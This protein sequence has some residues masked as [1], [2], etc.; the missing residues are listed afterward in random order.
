VQSNFTLSGKAADV[1]DQLK[2]RAAHAKPEPRVVYITTI[3][4]PES[5][6]RK[7]RPPLSPFHEVQ[8]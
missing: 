4:T 3:I 6:A 5:F 8:G 1:F 2:A 7:R